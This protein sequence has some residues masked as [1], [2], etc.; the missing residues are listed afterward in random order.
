MTSPRTSSR[1]SDLRARRAD[2]A[3]RARWQRGA[4]AAAQAPRRRAA[5]RPDDAGHVGHRS[6][7]ARKIAPETEVV[8]MTAYGTVETAVEAMKEGAYDFVTKPLKRAHVVRVVAQGAR[9]AVAACR[10]TASLQGAARR[11]AAAARSS[12]QSL[13][14][15]GARWTSSCRRR[16]RRRPCCCSARAGTGKELLARAHPRALAARA[17]ARSSRSTAP[18]CPRRSSRPSCS[19]T[20]RAP[21]PAR[22]PRRDGRFELADGGT[23]FLDEIGEI[24]PHVQVKL[25]RVLQEGEVERLGG[26]QTMKVDVRL[27]AATNR[28]LARGGA[29]GP[30]PRGPLLPAQRHRGA[31]AAA[32]RA[33]RRHPA[34][35]AST[36]CSVY[37]RARTAS[38]SRAARATALERAARATPGRATC[39]S[40][41]TRSS[42]RS[43][44]R[45][46]T[47]HRA[48]RPAAGGAHGRRRAGRRPVAVVRRRD[49]AR[50]DRAAGDPRDAA[51]HQGRQAPGAQ[52]LGI[53]TRTIYRKLE[54]E[55]TAS[56][57]PPTIARRPRRPTAGPTLPAP[58]PNW[59]PTGAAQ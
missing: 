47:R 48:R 16:R 22:S 41:R 27:V 37:A 55:R 10:R 50:G 26:T 31:R 54:E 12:A 33:P 6:A 36:S 51:P 35:G 45:A 56:P 29:R 24:P 13:R 30:L 18:R 57:T 46:A 39:A 9:E 14:A 21:S 20:R 38:R 40:W 11:R 32:A 15:G 2:R 28:D 5:H 42:A 3:R 1:S 25:L 17:R 34:A 53:A 59:Q 58:V 52:L 43:C 44:C 7:A 8:L 49:A 19:A 4:R 23:L